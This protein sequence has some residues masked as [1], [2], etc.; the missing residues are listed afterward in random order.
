[1]IEGLY[2]AGPGVKTPV[3]GKCA[4]TTNLVERLQNSCTK[5]ITVTNLHH[6][7]LQ[8]LKNLQSSNSRPHGVSPQHVWQAESPGGFRTIELLRMDAESFFSAQTSMAAH[9]IR[10][11][12]LDRDDQV[13]KAARDSAVVPGHQATESIKTIRSVFE[14]ID[15]L[16]GPEG[17]FPDIATDESMRL[18]GRETATI[19]DNNSIRH[20]VFE[21]YQVAGFREEL[22]SRLQLADIEKRAP[23]TM[24][25][26]IAANRQANE[27]IV[28]FLSQY[29]TQYTTHFNPKELTVFAPLSLG[30]AKRLVNE[31]Q[32]ECVDQLSDLCTYTRLF[33]DN[34]FEYLGTIQG[35]LETAYSNGL[36]HIRVHI[37]TEYPFRPPNYAFITKIYHPNIGP[38]GSICVDMLLQS[39]ASD[40]WGWSPALTISRV[41]LSLVSFLATP[42]PDDPHPDSTDVAAHYLRDRVG[43]HKTAEEWTRKYATGELTNENNTTTFQNKRQRGHEVEKTPRRFYK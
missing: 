27:E 6:E 20:S 17:A 8:S 22:L 31:L 40:D 41:L 18:Y 9:S 25:G 32:Q 26:I 1:M 28:S 21:S 36:F 33:D 34:M 4:F 29:T 43:F 19:P 11:S 16:P 42:Q 7:L 5:G 10:L 30:L 13:L 37:P 2:A 39:G 35:P 14:V 15:T 3:S 23:Q 38:D 12:K 24:T